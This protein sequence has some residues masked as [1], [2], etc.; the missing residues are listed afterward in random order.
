VVGEAEEGCGIPVENL[1][2]DMHA[3]DKSMNYTVLSR[4][5]DFNR[6]TF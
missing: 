3:E 1:D 4:G 6:F 5:R 2:L